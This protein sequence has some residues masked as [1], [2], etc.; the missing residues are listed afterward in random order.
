MR[1]SV[2]DYIRTCTDEELIDLISVI[3]DPKIVRAWAIKYHCA[4]SDS[5]AIRLW[6]KEEMKDA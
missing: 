3:I 2:K 5:T 6:L 1:C 4:D